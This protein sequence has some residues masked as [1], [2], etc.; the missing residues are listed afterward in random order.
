MQIHKRECYH[1]SAEGH[2][3]CWDRHLP[4]LLCQGKVMR[5][6]CGHHQQGLHT[7]LLNCDLP[8]VPSG[9]ARRLESVT[10]WWVW[11][12]NH[13][14]CWWK[15][16]A[17]SARRITNV[18][19]G[20]TVFCGVS[21]LWWI[22][23]LGTPTTKDGKSICCRGRGTF[24]H[25]KQKDDKS[26]CCFSMKGWKDLMDGGGGCPA[27][28]I[29]IDFWCPAHYMIDFWCPAHHMI[30]FWCPA[31]HNWFLMPCQPHDWFQMPCLPHND[32]FLMPC[33]PCDDRF[34]MPCPPFNIW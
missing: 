34:L 20:R 3:D 17:L 12:L 22:K 7:L 19:L 26:M 13:F 9:A 6:R 27:Y 5:W 23:L 1:F 32:R 25:K 30:D 2:H 21:A 24:A 16:L 4:R 15:A 10:E 18:D 11:M 31:H 28:H 14:V 29:M 33:Q 8:N